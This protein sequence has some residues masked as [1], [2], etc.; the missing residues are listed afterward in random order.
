MDFIQET[1]L[2][3]FDPVNSEPVIC[4]M[5]QLVND[6]FF[7]ETEVFFVDLLS[8]DPAVTFVIQTASI[9]I[10]NDD[11]MLLLI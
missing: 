7:E 9:S 8:S 10:I 2:I 6:M 3:R 4:E 11:S 5:L 1:A